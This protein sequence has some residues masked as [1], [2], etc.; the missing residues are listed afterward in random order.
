MPY[1][2]TTYGAG[3]YK[4]E[5]ANPEERPRGLVLVSVTQQRS[6]LL[7]TINR[8]GNKAMVLNFMSND[9]HEDTVTDPD[10]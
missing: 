4:G 2:S 5:G 3:P 9:T 1:G 6:I 10:A 8:N 7:G